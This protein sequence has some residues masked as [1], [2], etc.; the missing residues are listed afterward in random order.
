MTTECDGGRLDIYANY[1]VA[2][3]GF[4]QSAIKVL[5]LYI[6]FKNNCK[7][8]NNQFLNLSEPEVKSKK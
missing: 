2:N 7:Q 6:L 1:T 3:L 4:T 8:A 5:F